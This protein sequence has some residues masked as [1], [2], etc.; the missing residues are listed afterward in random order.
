[1]A[2]KRTP[3]PEPDRL[4]IEADWEEAMKRA[5]AKP[6]PPEG[7]PGLKKKGRAKKPAK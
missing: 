4:K 2:A 7:W 5:L 3:G 6:R 1:M